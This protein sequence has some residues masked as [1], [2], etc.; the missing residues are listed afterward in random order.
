VAAVLIFVWPESQEPTNAVRRPPTLPLVPKR[1]ESPPRTGTAAPVIATPTA[2][3]P[4]VAPPPAP[5]VEQIEAAQPAGEGSMIRPD[6]QLVEAP[7][8]TSPANADAESLDTLARTLSGES[9]S[10]RRLT[11][12]GDE[13]LDLAFTDDCWV[14]IKDVNG[15]NLYSDLARAGATLAFVGQGPFRILLG[16]GPAVTLAFN[17]APVPLRSYTRNNVASLVVGG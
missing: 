3:E 13:R 15:R 5:A 1:P 11:P 9:E 7:P 17:G 4:T 16:Y 10:V 2:S 6:A 8:A 14:E 12:A